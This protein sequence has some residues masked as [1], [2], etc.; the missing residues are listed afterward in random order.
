MCSVSQIYF[1]YKNR[2][3]TQYFHWPSSGYL[4]NLV[5]TF[6]LRARIIWKWAYT[7]FKQRKSQ[8]Y[9]MTVRWI[10]QITRGDSTK[11]WYSA[12]PH[13]TMTM[14]F[15]WS[16]RHVMPRCH[17]VFMFRKYI[18]MGQ[19]KKDVTPVCYQGSYVFLALTHRY[20]TY[21]KHN[22]NTL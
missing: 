12:L 17:S 11:N 2:W 5:L 21:T 15:F 10:Q 1:T 3:H 9:F 8:R 14:A 20:I 18:S 4:S 6:D 7:I 16:I 13:K 22:T 19:R